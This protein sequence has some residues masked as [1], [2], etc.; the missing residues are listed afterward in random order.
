[1]YTGKQGSMAHMAG[2]RL[3]GCDGKTWDFAPWASALLALEQAA[4]LRLLN[5][6]QRAA[7][8]E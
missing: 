1:M 5:Q 8:T 2:Y 6:Q 7:G 4:S 3:P